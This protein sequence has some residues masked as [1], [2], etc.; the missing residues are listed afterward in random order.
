VS[1][2]I[3]RCD[4]CGWSIGWHR[5]A[6]LVHYADGAHELRNVSIWTRLRVWLDLRRDYKSGGSG[7]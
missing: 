4:A 2:K 3:V 6:Y 1:R 7:S 5:M